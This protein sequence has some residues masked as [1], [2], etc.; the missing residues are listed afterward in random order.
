MKHLIRTLLI[1][2]FVGLSLS[3][4]FA[5]RPSKNDADLMPD[6]TESGVEIKVNPIGILFETLLGEIEFHPFENSGVGI[7]FGLGTFDGLGYV[8]L[9]HKYYFNPKRGW[10]KVHIISQLCFIDIDNLEGFGAGFGVGY[11]VVSQQKVLF[12]LNFSVNRV[13]G[14]E[15]FPLG[16]FLVGYR[17]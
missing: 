3:A 17:F 11:K 7:D 5:Q 8:N 10:D 6:K 16:N 2:A 1:V 13:I 12:E 9:R 14:D 15:F 4:T